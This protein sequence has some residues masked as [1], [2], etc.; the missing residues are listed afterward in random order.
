MNYIVDLSHKLGGG[1]P[2]EVQVIDALHTAYV[3]FPSMFA[4]QKFYDVLLALY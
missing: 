4:A 1:A 2:D 3:T